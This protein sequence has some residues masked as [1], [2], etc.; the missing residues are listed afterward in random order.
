MSQFTVIEYTGNQAGP[1]PFFGKVTRIMYRFGKRSKRLAVDSRDVDGLLA[2]REGRQAVFTAVKAEVPITVI[3]PETKPL[4]PV[5]ETTNAPVT[6]IE[7]KPVAPI[8]E[9]PVT[10]P[11]KTAPFDFLFLSGVGP[12]R[13]EKLF[14]AGITTAE[15]F[16]GAG[17][18][19]IAAI[20]GAPVKV[21]AQWIK[22]IS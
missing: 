17:A 15:Q 14:D 5:A 12:A 19:Q 4:V 18:A 22:V 16:I 13:N 10:E 9:V 21:A 20:T 1:V 3:E 11:V 7:T 8:V 6:E 2:V